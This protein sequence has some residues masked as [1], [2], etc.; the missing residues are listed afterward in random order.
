MNNF[1]FDTFPFLLGL[2]TQYEQNFYCVFLLGL[3]TQYEQNFLL[4]LFNASE[5]LSPWRPQ[6]ACSKLKPSGMPTPFGVRSD[7]GLPTETQDLPTPTSR[8]GSTRG[9]KF[10]ICGFPKAQGF[11]HFLSVGIG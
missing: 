8:G 10:R 11:G 6:A 3:Q 5:G 9:F 7:S 4:R 2:Q 1:F